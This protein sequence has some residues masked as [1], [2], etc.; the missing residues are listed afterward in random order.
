MFFKKLLNRF[1]KGNKFTLE[2]EFE[3]FKA[4]HKYSILLAVAK[5]YYI[6][7][8]QSGRVNI[9]AFMQANIA[10][11]SAKKDL[12]RL[13]SLPDGGR[14]FNSLYEK[15]WQEVANLLD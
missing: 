2:S 8:Q 9:P 6:D 10:E 14:K 13:L 3:Q 5:K 12:Q 1:K 7:L 4:M 15:A 11:E